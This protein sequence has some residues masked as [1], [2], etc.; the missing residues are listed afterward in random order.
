[1]RL[2]HDEY[3]LKMLDLVAA[4]STCA[5]RAV[6]AIIVD[7][8]HR[9]LSTGYNGVPSGFPHC[10][11]KP[12]PGAQH[13]KGDTRYCMAVHAEINAIIQCSQLFRAHKMYVSCSPCFECAKAIVNTG[14]K[15]V[16]CKETYFVASGPLG[17]D[18]FAD[19]G[20]HLEVVKF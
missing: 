8:K 1:M 10:T 9:V 15:I 13:E 14:I 12:C 11:D 17:T 5:R 19:A 3:Y 18:V 16:V 4:R 7:S 20:V 2:S 6:G